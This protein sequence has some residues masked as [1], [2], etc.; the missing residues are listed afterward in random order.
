MLYVS[1]LN[2]S[3][4]FNMYFRNI[5]RFDSS[6][7]SHI[8]NST[9]NGWKL[10]VS[11]ALLTTVGIV[12]RLSLQLIPSGVN[13]SNNLII[14]SKAIGYSFMTTGVIMTILGALKFCSDA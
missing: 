14:S 12:T 7:T 6:N 4:Y 10:A 5:G 3:W 13:V 11:G 1:I 8:P 2:F 9:C